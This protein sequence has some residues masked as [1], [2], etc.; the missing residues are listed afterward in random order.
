MRNAQHAKKLSG[1]VDSAVG[2]YFENLSPESLQMFLATS[3]APVQEVEGGDEFYSVTL[4]S[5]LA[6]GGSAIG[7]N[8]YFTT[9]FDSENVL[10]RPSGPQI[11]VRAELEELSSG[12]Y[13]YAL[14]ISVS[15]YYPP[16]EMAEEFEE[17]VFQ[18]LW[19]RSDE[20]ALLP[21]VNNQ[22]DQPDYRLELYF[23]DLEDL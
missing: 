13:D 20:T 18:E 15:G 19:K 7:K 1:L 2:E 9:G 12:S 10:E 22:F 21:P 3:V 14:E 5:F 6:E 16:G 23:E 4:E 8:Y 17:H 11:S